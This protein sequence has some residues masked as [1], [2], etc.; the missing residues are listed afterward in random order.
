MAR[1]KLTDY[2]TG[3]PV[4][5]TFSINPISF[6][7]PGRTANLQTESTTAP[8]GQPIVF[9]G[10]DK[11]KRLSFSGLVYSQSAYNDLDTWKDKRNVLELTDDQGQTWNVLFSSWNWTRKKSALN[12]WR[13]DYNAEAIVM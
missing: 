1:W 9:Q 3:S 8:N 5:L 10:Y 7:P 11:N 12:Q 6:T 13:F 2:S 4:E